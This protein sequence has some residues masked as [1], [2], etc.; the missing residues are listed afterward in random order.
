M[1]IF[2]VRFHAPDGQAGIH[3]LRRV[4]KFA[5]RVCGLRCDDAREEKSAPTNVADALVQL[6]H[7]V[8]SRLRG[9]S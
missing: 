8:N 5:V 1:S 4:L 9:R 2:I 7:D 6:H 3:A